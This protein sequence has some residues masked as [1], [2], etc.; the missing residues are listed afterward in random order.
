MT[1]KITVKRE[2]D[3]WHVTRPPFGFTP[4][5]VTVYPTGAQAIASLGRH[6]AGTAGS[7][8]ALNVGSYVPGLP[9]KQ[10]QAVRPRWLEAWVDGDDERGRR[11][12]R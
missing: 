11:D 3:G 5:T 8:A 2:A 9:S 7:S 4:A 1:V 6:A 10:G 12:R